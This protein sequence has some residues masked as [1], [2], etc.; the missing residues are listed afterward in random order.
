MAL[1]PEGDVL[2]DGLAE[3]VGLLE[4]HADGLADLVDVHALGVDIL[5]VVPDGAFHAGVGDLVVHEVQ[6]TQ[7]RGLTASGRSDQRRD[8]AVVEVYADAVDSALLA[9]ID[10]DIFC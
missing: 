6:R 5:A 9:V 4:H 2:A 7:V 10:L 1:E 8:G 3:R